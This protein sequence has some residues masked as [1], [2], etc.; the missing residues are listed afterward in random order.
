M[1]GFGLFLALA[2]SSGACSSVAASGHWASPDGISLEWSPASP[3]FGDMVTLIARYPLG[4]SGDAAKKVS[5]VNGQSQGL[6]DPDAAVADSLSTRVEG[7]EM[8]V[9]WVLRVTKAGNWYWGKNGK[10][11]WNIASVAGKETE[12]KSFDAKALW[13]GRTLAVPSPA[14]TD[15]TPPAGQP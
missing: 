15:K 2:V 11:L 7:R 14:S 3:Q 8:L 13:E 1:A 10:T 5:L 12:L 9:S 4:G 6:Y